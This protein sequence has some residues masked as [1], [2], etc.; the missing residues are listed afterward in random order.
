MQTILNMVQ[1]RFGQTCAI[2][3][4]PAKHMIYWGVAY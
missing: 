1:E 3:G 2:C 4:K